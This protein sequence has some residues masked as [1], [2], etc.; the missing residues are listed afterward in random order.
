MAWFV[1]YWDEINSRNAR[2][3][4]NSAR[5]DTMWKAGGLIR[6][7]HVASHVASPHGERIDI[8]EL[9]AAPVAWRSWQ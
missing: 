3:S 1:Y 6:E 8:I 2:F 7:G 4:E 5:E 9:Q